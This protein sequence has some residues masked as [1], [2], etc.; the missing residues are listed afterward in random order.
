MAGLVVGIPAA[1]VDLVQA[2]LLERAFQDPLFPGLF[3]RDEASLEEWEANSGQTLTVTRAGLLSPATTPLTPG[4]DPT[5]QTVNYEQWIATLQRY[6]GTIDTHMPTSTIALSSLFLRNMNTLGLQAAQTLNRVPRNVIFQAYLSGSTCTTASNSSSDTAIQVASLNGFTTVVTPGVAGNTGPV[7]VSAANPLQVTVGTET[8]NVIG[9]TANNPLDLN[10]PGTLTISAGLSSSH[11]IRT[12]V[13]SSAAP[14]ILRSG[15][16]GSSVDSISSSSTLTIQDLINA[17]NKLRFLNV[18]PHEDGTYHCHIPPSGMSQLFQDPALRILF[19]GQPDSKEFKS[20]VIGYMSGLKLI[21]NNE[22]PNALNTG[23]QTG[24]GNSA[25]Y[26]ADI[27]AEILNSSGQEIARCIVTGKDV[28]Y[29]KYLDESKYITEAGVTGKIGNFAITNGGI[30]VMADRC[31]LIMRAPLDRLQ[32]MVSTSWSISTS[33]T[34]PT[35]ISANGPQKF[36]RAVVIEFAN[37]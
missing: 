32:D 26:A 11:A 5:P 28:M 13:L 12:T 1:V 14:I 4:T 10:G 34:A 29:E 21:L 24:T 37:S 18:A 20:G 23:T 22:S 6:G 35:D 8:C 16:N 3:Y 30:A 27:G 19:Q 2:G 7:P 9:F 33:F 25:E 17:S 31:R 36:K 15:G